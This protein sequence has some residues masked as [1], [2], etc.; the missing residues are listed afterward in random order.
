MS[1]KDLIIVGAGGFGRELAVWAPGALGY[2]TDWFFKGYID[3]DVSAVGGSILEKDKVDSDLLLGRIHDF[4]PGESDVLVC[5]I[6]DP[7]ERERVVSSLRDKG[8]R[9]VNFIHRTALLAPDLLIG[10]GN[11]V[12]P[13]VTITCSVSVGNYNIFNSKTSVGHDVS[14]GDFNSI[15]GACNIGGGAR[16]ADKCFL[17]T[18]S[19]VMPNV[20][21]GSSSKIGTGSVAIRAVP[22]GVTVFGCPAKRIT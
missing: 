6:A 17:G 11:I 20:K 8:G 5:A 13:F 1:L 19:V 22:S 15:M 7:F 9:F 16:I 2:G 3:D 21:V 14:I 4:T 18:Q 10:T 12:C